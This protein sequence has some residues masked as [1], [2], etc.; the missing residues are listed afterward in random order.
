MSGH[1]HWAGIKHRKALTDFKRAGAF[2]KM[3]RLI[4]VA[5]REGGGNPDFNFKLKIA[6]QQARS[7][8]MP[9]D[10]IERSIKK[11]TGELKDAT[12]I[13]ELIY[14][15]YGPGQVAMLIKTLTDNRNRTLTEVKN[16]L[17]KN[18]GKMVP[19]GSVSFLFSQFGYST[20]DLTD[21][22]RDEI[23]LVA[24]DAGAEDISEDNNLMTIY[25]KPEKLAE[26]RKKFEAKE[27]LIQEEGITFIASQKIKLSE[28]DS[29][30]YQ[31]LLEALESSDDIQEIF[32]NL[33]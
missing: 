31:A 11:G 29:Q 1:S 20:L 19:E 2:T 16:I 13:E 9:K 25:T 7:L 4:T 6:I 33:E 24:I 32:D 10:N 8:N 30:K 17:N 27:N 15:A 18:N 22:N 28:K 12:T 5:A 14:E 3:A 26:I 23:E 21:Q